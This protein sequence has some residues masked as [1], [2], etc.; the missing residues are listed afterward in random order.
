MGFPGCIKTELAELDCVVVSHEVHVACSGGRENP[1]L[2]PQ[3]VNAPAEVGIVIVE[4]EVE[5][6]SA[7][8]LKGDLADHERVWAVECWKTSRVRRELL[9]RDA[10]KVVGRLRCPSIEIAAESPDG[11]VLVAVDMNGHWGG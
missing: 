6:E 10:G 5:V 2:E 4:G 3:I 8:L 1:V 11:P 9:E 7:D